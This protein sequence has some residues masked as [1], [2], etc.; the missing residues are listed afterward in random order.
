MK[1]SSK[2]I[3]IISPEKQF[4]DQLRKSTANIHH[5]VEA[6]PVSRSLMS[7]QVTL[8][9]YLFYMRCMQEV[10]E[11]YDDVIIPR[12]KPYF[13]DVEERKKL[14]SLS[15]DIRYLSQQCNF[16]QTIAPLE[17]PV[18]SSDA[19]AVGMAYVIEGSTLG[20]RVILKH[21]QQ[22]F[23]LEPLTGAAFFTGYSQRTGSM[24]R[25]FLDLLTQ[26]AI[27]QQQEQQIIDGAI[28]GFNMI[29]SH[30]FKNSKRH[31]N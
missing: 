18:I 24:W 4:L 11:A 6:L 31:E 20:G 16:S 13:P 30:L 25:T 12:I 29:Y 3:D 2:A 28:Q 10:M 19:V 1:D 15:K 22:R 21:I 26:Y 9:D 7:D 5:Q 17:M 27:Q 14:P 8:E 23:D